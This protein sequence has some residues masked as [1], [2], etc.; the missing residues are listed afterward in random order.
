MNREATKN[1][2]SVAATGPRPQSPAI[3]AGLT[4]AEATDRVHQCKDTP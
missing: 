3:P 2:L 1:R 4:P